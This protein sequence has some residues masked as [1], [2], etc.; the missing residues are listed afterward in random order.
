[1]KQPIYVEF[2][3]FMLKPRTFRLAVSGSEFDIDT[4]NVNLGVG[5]VIHQLDGDV[6]AEPALAG[7]PL[8]SGPSRQAAV[9]SLRAPGQEPGGRARALLRIIRHIGVFR[10]PIR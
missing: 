9:H 10:P 3:S 2:Y 5:C 8:P 6:P 1:M 7:R 4:L